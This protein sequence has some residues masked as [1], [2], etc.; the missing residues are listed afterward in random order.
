MSKGGHEVAGL[1]WFARG[2]VVTVVVGLALTFLPTTSRAA[3]TYTAT[4]NAR[5][6][7]VD[8]T[9]VPAIAFDQLVDAGVSAAQAQIDSLGNDPGV[10]V[11]AVPERLGGAPPRAGRRHHRGP[12]QRPHPA[13]PPDR[14]HQR[15]HPGR[16]PRA[17][18]RSSSTRESTAGNS[19]GSVTDGATRAVA[20]T[21]A[22]DAR[23]VAHAE[24]TISSLQLTPVLSLDGVRTTADATRAAD[25]D[26]DLS[27]SFEVAA[28]IDPRPAAS[29]SPPPRCPCSAATSPSGWTCRACSDSS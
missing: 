4:A 5:L 2:F 13:V 9:A 28:I 11:V 16:P 12:D 27:S 23:V 8:F 7:G 20:R 25:G 19:R 24:T 22:D 21:T 26:I 1:R 29:R 3:G 10:R 17:G 15:D 6:V 14:R 18:H